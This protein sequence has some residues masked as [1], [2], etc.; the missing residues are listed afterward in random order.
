MRTRCLVM[1][2]VEFHADRPATL[3]VSTAAIASRMHLHVPEGAA[4]NTPVNGV[5]FLRKEFQHCQR[6]ELAVRDFE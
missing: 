2:N 5:A 1:T 3:P 6:S 4:F